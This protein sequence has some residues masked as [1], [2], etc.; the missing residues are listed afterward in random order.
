MLKRG[1]RFTGLNCITKVDIRTELKIKD[2][3]AEKAV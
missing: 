3:L 2:T 1:K